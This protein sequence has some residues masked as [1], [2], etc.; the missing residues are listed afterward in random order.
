MWAPHLWRQTLFF[1]EKNW[2][3]FLV[4]TVCQL[5]VLQCHPYLFSPEKL[6]NFFSASLSLLFISLVHS[7]DVAHYFR[8]VAMLQKKLP[9]LLLGHFVGAPVRPNMLNMPKSAAVFLAHTYCPS[10]ILPLPAN[11]LAGEI[12]FARAAASSHQKYISSLNL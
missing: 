4:I 8:H 7:G 5:S 10:L 11:K 3:P 12:V 1:L 2:R 9:L 6:A